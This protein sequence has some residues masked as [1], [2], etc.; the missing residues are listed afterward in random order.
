VSTNRQAAW[1]ITQVAQPT[2]L[3]LGFKRGIPAA[4]SAVSPM[5]ATSEVTR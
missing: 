4:G 1:V 5:T 2:P 3:N